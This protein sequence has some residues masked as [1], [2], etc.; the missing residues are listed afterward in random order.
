MRIAL[1]IRALT[2]PSIRG[3]AFY[4]QALVSYLLR[5]GHE[6]YGIYEKG[7]LNLPIPKNLKLVKVSRPPNLGGF[8]GLYW[9]QIILPKAVRSLKVDIYHA[10]D[11]DKMPILDGSKTVVTMHDVSLYILPNEFTNWSK[12]PI[13]E[14]ISRFSY[15]FIQKM[16][17]DAVIT[18][19]LA[20]K[21]DIVDKFNFNSSKIHVVYNGFNLSRKLTGDKAKKTLLS[22]KIKNPYFVFLG[23]IEPR[24]NLISLIKAFSLFKRNNPDD[25]HFLI[26][27]GKIE[28]VSAAESYFRKMNSEL[29]KKD[30]S[31]VRKF[32][33]FPGEVS[34][35]DKRAIYE[36]SDAL[37]YPSIYEG[38]GI[39]ILEA[40][41]VGTPVITSDTSGMKEVAGDAAYLINP[42]DVNSIAKG[43]EILINNKNIRKE[44]V[45]K[46]IERSKLFSWE[47]CGKETEEVYQRVL[48]RT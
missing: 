2:K 15:I 20:S 10:T 9:S 43:L 44:L 3:I 35:E 28:N 40:M 19:S 36:M 7:E 30:N 33:L 6:V 37:V 47:K 46:G 25:S 29:S 13:S 26:I 4:E 22:Y 34:E 41:G 8:G 21:K 32:V 1:D 18:V 38:F 17:A 16:F 11:N 31:Q 39:P 27:A 12:R 14:K 42:F 48:D 24:K 5:R 23:G 45:K